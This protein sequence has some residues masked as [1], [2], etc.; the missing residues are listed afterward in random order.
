MKGFIFR[1]SRMK[2]KRPKMQGP[3]S[4]LLLLRILKPHEPVPESP[5]SVNQAVLLN[6][7]TADHVL[8]LNFGLLDSEC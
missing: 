2:T 3:R 1:D 4:G 8:L 6:L 5:V 7:Y